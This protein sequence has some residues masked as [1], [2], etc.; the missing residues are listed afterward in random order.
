MKDMIACLDVENK[1]SYS[2]SSC[3]MEKKPYRNS[4]DREG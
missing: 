3:V 4:I 2:D 1:I